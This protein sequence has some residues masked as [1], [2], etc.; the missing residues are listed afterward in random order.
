VNG[1]KYVLLHQRSHALANRSGDF[2]E[3]VAIAV[4][5]LGK[6]LP[7]HAEVHHVDGNGKNNA[8]SNL[9]I[10]ES[11]AYHRLLHVRARVVAAGGNPNTERVCGRCLAAKPIDEFYVIAGRGRE[12]ERT[13]TCKY[14]CRV[15]WRCVTKAALEARR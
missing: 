1:A 14:C 10:C 5:A 15:R 12:G 8:N 6:P 9:V 3:H 13:T 2:Y 4:R 7:K 11:R